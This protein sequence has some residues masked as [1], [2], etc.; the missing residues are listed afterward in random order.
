MYNIANLILEVLQMRV[1]LAFWAV[2]LLLG[3]FLVAIKFLGGYKKW[4]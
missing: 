3:A 2:L 1:F 4:L